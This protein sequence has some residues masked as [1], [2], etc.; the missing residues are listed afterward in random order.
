MVSLRLEQLTVRLGDTTVLRDLDLWVDSGTSLAVLGQSGSGK[1]TLLRTIAGLEHPT[2]GRVLLDNV[3]V[4][5]VSVADRGVVLV[6]QTPAL[7]PNLNLADNVGRPLKW[8]DRQQPPET[9]RRRVMNELR[10]FGLGGRGHKS[11]SRQSSLRAGLRTCWAREVRN[12]PCP[13]SMRR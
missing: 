6:P 4:A 1:S 2:A 12:L 3:D 11:T 7:Q 10:R 8:A 5:N 13:D 9:R